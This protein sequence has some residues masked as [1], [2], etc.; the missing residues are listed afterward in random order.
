MNI[1][2]GIKNFMQH[3]GDPLELIGV[4]TAI[5]K[6]M[7]ESSKRGRDIYPLM[8]GIDL[9]DPSERTM[10]ILSGVY[11]YADSCLIQIGMNQGYSMKESCT[12]LFN[13]YIEKLKSMSHTI[14]KMED[15]K[16]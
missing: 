7:N 16:Q 4:E 3:F 14:D 12:I 5:K 13:K 11:T 6:L 10:K 1:E 8:V 15:E 2:R 9:H